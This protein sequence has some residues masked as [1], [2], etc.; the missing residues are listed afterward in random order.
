MAFSV[1]MGYPEAG[2]QWRFHWGK[3]P[4]EVES[5]STPA[6]KLP[7]APQ[8]GQP[9]AILVEINRERNRLRRG[10]GGIPISARF[11]SICSVD[12]YL[13]LGF[14]IT[15]HKENAITQTPAHGT[16]VPWKLK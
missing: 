3:T 14:G 16:S 5:P 4:I 7:Y 1:L 15:I 11:D 6:P 8:K 9:L 10:E 12:G 2:L 13:E